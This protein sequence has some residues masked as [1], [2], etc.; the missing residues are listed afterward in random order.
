MTL[1][2]VIAFAAAL[3]HCKCY[4][5]IAYLHLPVPGRPYGSTSAMPKLRYFY[6]VQ[7][8]CY[9]QP[10][11]FTGIFS[12]HPPVGIRIGLA[13]ELGFRVRVIGLDS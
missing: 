1:R 8:V 7:Y 12:F 3:V 5:V 9:L 11:I 10:V 13:K 6:N 4:A 2:L